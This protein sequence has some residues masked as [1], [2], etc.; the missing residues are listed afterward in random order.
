MLKKFGERVAMNSPIQGS[1]ADII[2][3]A[4]IGTYKA[5]RQAGI[6]AVLVL[7]VHDELVLDVAER[8]ADRA[9]QLL[10]E[11][12]EGVISSKVPLTCE[13]SLG[14]TWFDCK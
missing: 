8:D 14:K 3:L 5:L 10:R 7:Q 6:D 9:S 12:M 2:K 13:V 4:M 1:A 11:Q